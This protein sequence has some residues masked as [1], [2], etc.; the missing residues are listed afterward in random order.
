MEHDCSVLDCI[1]LIKLINE[2]AQ[3][4]VK[5]ALAQMDTFCLLSLV[6]KRCCL[7]ICLNKSRGC[8]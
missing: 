3:V 7:K 2:V 6:E 4:L 8:S 5:V 1:A